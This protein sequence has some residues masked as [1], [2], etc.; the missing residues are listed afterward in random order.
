MSVTKLFGVLPFPLSFPKRT[1]LAHQKL[2]CCVSKNVSKAVTLQL[3]N[4][5]TNPQNICC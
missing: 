2:Q 1:K 5:L 3:L 4:Q